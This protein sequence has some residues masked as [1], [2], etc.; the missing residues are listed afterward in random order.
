MPF[1][2]AAAA[3]QNLHPQLSV[4]CRNSLSKGLRFLFHQFGAGIQFLRAE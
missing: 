4:K 1:I 3:A 2:G